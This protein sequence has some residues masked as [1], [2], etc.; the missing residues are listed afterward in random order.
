MSRFG[1]GIGIGIDFHVDRSNLFT[2][3]RPRRS[4][5]TKKALLQA[6]GRLFAAKGYH[7]T[8]LRDILTAARAPK[9]SFYNF[10]SSKEAYAGEVIERYADMLIRYYELA[11]GATDSPREQLRT[12]HLGLIA[13]IGGAESCT[14]CLIG[15]LSGE[16]GPSHEEMRKLLQKVERRW[17]ARLAE[18]FAA[19]QERGEARKDLAPEEMAEAFW[20][21]W[22]GAHLRS[23]LEQ[24]VAPLQ[25]ALAH[26]LDVLFAP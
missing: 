16:L 3:G 14:G 2:M 19:A 23:E 26:A 12:A 4:E 22:Q 7:G 15:A 10:F 24:S 8:G 6:G 11:A 13:Y 18:T 5:E 25:R 9:G 21:L 20:N 1:T 17:V